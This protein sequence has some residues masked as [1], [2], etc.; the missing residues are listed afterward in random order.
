MH[1]NAGGGTDPGH[2]VKEAQ[3]TQRH[4][5]TPGVLLWLLVL[6]QRWVAVAAWL[7]GCD[8]AGQLSRGKDVFFCCGLGCCCLAVV[9]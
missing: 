6:Q 7:S 3:E 4:S 9:I 1:V 2:T 8:A 5:A